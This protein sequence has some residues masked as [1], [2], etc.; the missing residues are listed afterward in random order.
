MGG[1]CKNFILFKFGIVGCVVGFDLG[2]CNNGVFLFCF[3][4]CRSFILFKLSLY[5]VL[6]IGIWRKGKIFFW[7]WYCIV[8]G[9]GLFVV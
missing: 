1:I 3:G 4:I 2:R 7:F 5:D 9:G 6:I 8:G